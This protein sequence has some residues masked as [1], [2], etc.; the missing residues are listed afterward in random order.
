MIELPNIDLGDI[1]TKPLQPSGNRKYL[2]KYI[3]PGV[4]SMQIDNSS[5]EVFTTCDRAAE[6][7]LLYARE[8]G[9]HSALR[10][11]SAIHEGLEFWYKSNR[12]PH[13]DTLWEGMVEAA[14]QP[15]A[16]APTQL[17]DWRNLDRCVDTLSKYRA[18]YP[19]E[20]FEI[21][22]VNG[23]KQVELPFSLPMGVIELSGEPTS[24]TFEQ[25]VDPT[26]WPDT[27]E[28]MSKVA[29]KELHVYWTG[30]MD[31]AINM[32][33]KLWIMDHKTSSIAGSSKKP[34]PNYFKEFELSQQTI[35]YAWAGQQIYG[36]EVA[37]LL[38]NVLV[39]RR[40]TKTGIPT[41]F[42]RQ[43]LYYRQDQISEWRTDVLTLISDFASNLERSFFPRKTKWCVGK[44]GTCPYF[45]VCTMPDAQRLPMLLSDYFVNTTWSPLD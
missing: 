19:T 38:V 35:G 31:V 40:P 42:I 45:D 3:S 26:T 2:L 33:N 27:W 14:S 44:Y 25:I 1:S 39:G 12:D 22:E 36:E 21:L 43:R 7:K 24:Y 16:D 37:G 34:N 10:Y 17:G 15:F 28:P 18:K 30:K 8:A 29:I 20:P 32:D 4:F 9:S 23:I 13:D 41:D 11:G 6:Y 5:M